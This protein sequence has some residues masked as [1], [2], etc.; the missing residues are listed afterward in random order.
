LIVAVALALSWP[1]AA[2]IDRELAEQGLSPDHTATGPA[3]IGLGDEL[4]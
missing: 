4:L 3:H 2:A 1:A